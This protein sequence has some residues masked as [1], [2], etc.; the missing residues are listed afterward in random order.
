VRQGPHLLSIFCNVHLSRR[1]E[2]II[3]C[4]S[5]FFAISLPTSNKWI[6][7]FH[8]DALFTKENIVLIWTHIALSLELNLIF[9]LNSRDKFH[10][11]ELMSSLLT[12]KVLSLKSRT[13]ISSISGIY[14][15]KTES[16]KTKSWEQPWSTFSNLLKCFFKQRAQSPHPIKLHS[17]IH[18]HHIYIWIA[19][20]SNTDS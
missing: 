4:A 8:K 17:F 15:Q 5:G 19:F 1:E 6:H 10:A 16:C 13:L 9:A 18:F 7:D 12:T 14:P 3:M 11:E 20:S 2:I